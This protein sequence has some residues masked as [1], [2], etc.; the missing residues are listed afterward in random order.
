MQKQGYEIVNMQIAPSGMGDSLM[1][2][3]V[4]VVYK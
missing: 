3:M 2:C 4:L 1:S